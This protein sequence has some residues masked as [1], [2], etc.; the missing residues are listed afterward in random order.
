M[1]FS[2]TLQVCIVWCNGMCSLSCRIIWRLTQK[3]WHWWSHSRTCYSHTTCCVYVCVGRILR[4]T[5]VVDFLPSPTPLTRQCG[6]VSRPFNAILQVQIHPNS[7]VRHFEL[8][9][10][11]P[12]GFRSFL[13]SIICTWALKLNDNTTQSNGYQ[14]VF[15]GTR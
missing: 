11:L 1:T 7:T 15:S 9:L 8:D 3:V 14:A 6:S 5:Y 13:L 2:D 12:V 10:E 4:P